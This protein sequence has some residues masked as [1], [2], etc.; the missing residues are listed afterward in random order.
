MLKIF[1]NLFLICIINILYCPF[2]SA[3]NESAV[4]NF[5]AAREQ[6]WPDWKLADLKHSNIQKDLIYPNWFEGDWIVY[7]EDNKAISDKPLIYKVNFHKNESGEIVGN[8]S[9]NSESIGKALFGDRLKKVENDPKSYNNQLIYLSDNEYIESRITK[10][11]QIFDN[12]LFWAD[13]FAL[14][15]VHKPEA[16][17]VNQVE[18]MSKFYR[19]DNGNLQSVDSQNQDICGFQ[20]LATYGSRVGQNNIKAISHSQYKLIFKHLEK[21][22]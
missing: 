3:G 9:A 15:T 1:F 8:R 18:V 21:K 2:V 22:R 17:R 12:N 16:S 19:C 14:Q 7:S 5:L 4:K 13:E 10:R 11:S 6:I 20:Y